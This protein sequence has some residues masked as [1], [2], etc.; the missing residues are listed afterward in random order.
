[1]DKLDSVAGLVRRLHQAVEELQPAATRLELSSPVQ[2]EW[3]GLL[4]NKLLAQLE[5]PP[6]LVVAIIGGTNIGKSVIFNHLAGEVASSVSPLAAHTK[7]PVCL[8]PPNLADP[9]LLGRLFESFSL[10]PWTSPDDPKQPCDENLLFWRIGAEIPPRLL[11]IDAP[12]VDSDVTVNW[13]R[14]RAIRQCAD[15]LLAVLT[16][17]KYNDAAVK[18][19]FREA[20]QADKAI[21]VLFNQ[22]HLPD[23]ETYWPAWLEAFCQSTGAE[24]ELVYVVPFN[25]VAAER[26][27]LPFYLVKRAAWPQANAGTDT[28]MST[29]GGLP[30]SGAGQTPAPILP[31]PQEKPQAR[32]LR[33]ELAKIHFEQIKIRTFRGALR[34]VLDPQRGAP[35]YR[36]SIRQAAQRCADAAQALSTTLEVEWPALPAGVLVNE[37]RLWWDERRSKWSKAVHGVYREVGRAMVWPVSVAL[38]R[39]RGR[40]EDQLAAFRRKESEAMLEAVKARLDELS[41]LSKIVNDMLRPRLLRLLGGIQRE[42]LCEEVGEAYW[43]L[44]AVDEDY[45][46]FLRSELDAW[47][48]SNPRVVR[49]LRSLDNAAAVA[50]PVITVTLLFTGLQ[51]AGKVVGDA[52]LQLAAQSAVH[53]ATEAAIA[54][55]TAAGGEVVAATTGEGIMQAAARLF[56]RL[57]HKYAQQRGKWLVDLLDKKLTEPELNDLRTLAAVLDSQPFAALCDALERL[58]QFL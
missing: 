25:R 48:Q 4:V 33:E 14:A 9:Q 39:L 6:L 46:Q 3:Y 7:H 1:M 11:L 30:A 10:R 2:Q 15:V 47:W 31:A 41:E 16:Q 27:R 34:R 28:G 35:A 29:T 8:A 52:A 24:P 37:F 22:V 21:I 32:D 17:Q 12:D 38:R 51:F 55:G 20:A 45:R 5:L 56:N 49:F 57:Q 50:R 58:E 23:D 13:E 53:L 26:L 18:Q 42:R 40:Q 36:E 43:Q 19:F 44:P 54:G